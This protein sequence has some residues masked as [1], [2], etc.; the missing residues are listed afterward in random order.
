[1]FNIVQDR[2][3]VSE[4]CAEFGGSLYNCDIY[5]GVTV[6]YRYSERAYFSLFNDDRPKFKKIVIFY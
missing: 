6:Y 3:G 1:M 4:G 5:I 2:Q